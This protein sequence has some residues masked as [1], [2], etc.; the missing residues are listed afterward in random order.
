[1]KDKVTIKMSLQL[2]DCEKVFKEGMDPGVVV[3]QE[4][5][6]KDVPEKGESGFNMFCASIL[7]YEDNFLKEN[8][9]VVIEEVEND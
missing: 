4:V 2:K 6:F 7:N 9:R 5:V 8:V 3:T 1:M